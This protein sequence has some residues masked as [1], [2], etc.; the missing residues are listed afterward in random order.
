[1]LQ[2]PES[3]DIPTETFTSNPPVAFNEVTPK[4]NGPREV[5]SENTIEKTTDLV[6]L[7]S[8]SHKHRNCN[9]HRSPQPFQTHSEYE[10]FLL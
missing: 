7:N 10:L 9:M 8:S 2:K 3:Q 5:S 4:Q 6:K 1:M